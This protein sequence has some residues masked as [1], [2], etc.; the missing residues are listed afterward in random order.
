MRA[1]LADPR[2]ARVSLPFAPVD[3]RYVR[4]VQTARASEA[5]WA[6]AELALFR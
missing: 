2:H 1:A 3:A 5:G 4:V 6:I